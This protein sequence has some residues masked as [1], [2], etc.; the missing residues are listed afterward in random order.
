MFRVVLIAGLC[1]SAAACVPLKNTAGTAAPSARARGAAAPGVPGVYHTIRPGETLWSISRW[2]GVDLQAITAANTLESSC[3]I[4]AGTRIFIPTERG[5]PQPAAAGSGNWRFVWPY[6]GTVAS[7]FNDYRHSVR[8]K[9]IDILAK[10]GA[11][12]AAAATGTVVFVSDNL[13][14][15]GKTV[16]IQHPENLLTVYAHNEENLVKLGESVRQGQYIAR[17]GST[18]RTNQCLVHFQVRKSNK[19]QNPLHYLP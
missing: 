10:P 19:A 4:S 16:I 9:G 7:C 12:V 15:Y 14:G 13:R 8:N 5:G 1:L 6:R 3:A 18:G 17:A 2:Y 11:M